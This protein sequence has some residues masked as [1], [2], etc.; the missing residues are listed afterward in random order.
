MNRARALFKEMLVDVYLL[1]RFVDERERGEEE[2]EEEE[3]ETERDRERQSARNGSG[4]HE[5]T[6][7]T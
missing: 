6:L 4:Q 2:E 5:L 1:F 3:R 7:W